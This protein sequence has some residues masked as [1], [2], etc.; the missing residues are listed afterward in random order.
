MSFISTGI[1]IGPLF[2]HYYGII[3]LSG[4]VIGTWLASKVGRRH[5]I[6]SEVYW[7]M[8]PWAL[9]FGIVGS[10]LWHVFMP[11]SSSGITFSYYLQHP[12]EILYI[13]N[14]GLGVPGAILGG[15]LGV[16]IFCRR[17]SFNFAALADSCAPGVALAQ[18]IGRWGNFVNQELYGKPTTL[19]WGITI[20]PQ[21]RIAAF[22]DQ[23]VYHPLFLYESIY[24]LLVMSFLL[25]LDSRQPK[26]LKDG[27][28]ILIYAI[29]YP[30]GR[31]CLEFLRLDPSMLGI[32]N[33]NQLL[34]ACIALT[35]AVALVIKQTRKQN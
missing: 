7:E 22:A 2:I 14:G 9:I 32:I 29:L 20:D 15:A 19:P 34:M 3:L 6:A 23:A 5:G 18:A 30:V 12:I 16:W 1:Q 31:F 10:R 25:W 33:G 4:A 13:W 27:S 24:N 8:L 17:Y 35:A 11:S 28:L 26:R 21:N